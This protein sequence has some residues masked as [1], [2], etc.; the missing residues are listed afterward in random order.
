[1]ELDEDSKKYTTINTH[2][3]LFEYNRLCFGIASAPGIFQRTIENLLQGIPNV[4]VRLDD[5]LIAGRTQAEHFQSLKEVLSR[6]EKVGIRL[7]RSKCVFQ[8]PEVTYLGHRI[9]SD[10]IYPLEEK[11]KAIQDSPRPTNLKEL[12]AFLGM[13]N[14]Y[15]C[16]I[17]N[18][19]SILAPLH[20]LL[21]KETLWEWSDAH[22]ESWNKAKSALHSSKLLV[23]YS[24]ERDVVIACDALPYG[25]GSV[26]SHILEDG[27]ERPISYASC[28]LSP[29][30][31][32][33]SQLDKEA[34]AVM[35][36]L[37]KFHTYLYG[38]RFKIYTDHKPLLGLLQSNKPIPTTASPRIQQW[39]LFLCGYL[40]ELVYRDGPSIGNAGGLSRLPLPT[41]IEKVPV[42]G[43]IM[44][45]ID[46]LDNIHVQVKDIESWTSHDPT[47]S[48][49]RH[50]A[51]S[52][53]LNP[54]D[55]VEYKP[56]TSRKTT[57][58]SGWMC[59]VGF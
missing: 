41:E 44:L 25:L 46:H 35:F 24:L 59:T 34:A 4:V 48:A 23:H 29:A 17:P 42:P 56:Y 9:T 15:S 55:S 57:Q 43:N 51:M 10:G 18:V 26:I 1:M 8:A 31:K 38:R 53:W 58:L 36:G 11:V 5:I 39:A 30:E 49:V 21:V 40:Y 52:G 54:D 7:K 12:Q 20:K 19:T 22:E 3:G 2:K 32:K 27:T 28:T 47:L 37:R 13:L 33:Y 45:V 14:Y 6:L 50:Q 16:Y